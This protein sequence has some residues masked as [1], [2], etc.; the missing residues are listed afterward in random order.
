[1]KKL[2]QIDKSN[3]NEINFQSE[4]GSE[5]ISDKENVRASTFIEVEKVSINLS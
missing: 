1:M 2:D 5:I 4:S 3:E